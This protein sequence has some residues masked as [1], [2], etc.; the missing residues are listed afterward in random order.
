MNYGAPNPSGSAPCG[1]NGTQL[2][3]LFEVNHEVAP[4]GSTITNNDTALNDGFYGL[5]TV[6]Q[7]D[8]SLACSIFGACN[9]ESLPGSPDRF[10]GIDQEPP[11]VTVTTPDP[12]VA[13]TTVTLDITTGDALPSSSGNI[14]NLSGVAKVQCSNDDVNFTTCGSGTVGWTIPSGDGV[15]TVYVKVTD[16]TGNTSEDSVNINLDTTSPT[17]H[18]VSPSAAS[19]SGWLLG[20]PSSF[21]IAG[22][23]ADTDHLDWW[24]DGGGH[25]SCSSPCT[26]TGGVIPNDGA[27]SFH[28]QAVDKVGNMEAA[29]DQPFMIDADKPLVALLTVPTAVDGSNGWFQENPFFVINAVDIT[30][31]S[32][33]NGITYK[34]RPAGVG[35]YGPDTPYLGPFQLGPGEWDICIKSQ[36]LAGNPAIPSGDGVN[37]VTGCRL[38]V[39]IDDAAPT[40]SLKTQ[41]GGL[42]HAPDGLN[43]WFVSTPTVV[44]TPSDATPG[45]GL[46]ATYASV[47]HKPYQAYTGPITIPEGLHEVRAFTVDNSGQVSN[48]AILPVKVDLSPAEPAAR[49]IPIDPARNGWFRR[50]S[51]A[52]VL[53]AQDGDQNAGTHKIV[54]QIVA[55]TASVPAACNPLWTTYTGQ[56]TTV[57]PGPH[58]VD[59]CTEDEAGNFSSVRSKA[60]NIDPDN[61]IVKALDANPNIWISVLG[62]LGPP[63]TQLQWQVTE[64]TSGKVT[65]SVVVYNLL[66]VP[67]RQINEAAP[68]T[69]TPGVPLNGSTPWDGKDNTLTGIVP[70]GVYYYRVVVTDDAGNTAMSGESRPITIKVK[71]L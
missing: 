12:T 35:A 25:T 68:R 59:F 8:N 31:G 18:L 63:T 60:F 44:A 23:N 49:T 6:V 32:G 7:N 54:Y 37:P 16:A 40:V 24:F 13:K 29:H 47:D 21:T 39:K 3:H 11:T 34:T 20:P 4:D 5:Y 52:F 15:H 38:D 56:L 26:V 2:G 51:P 17:S 55:P 1:S 71:L 27:H 14:D 62:I 10:I 58:R 61:P 53:R 9:T 43:G 57:A 65:V 64:P 46:A 70:A 36:D 22:D 41:I 45:S 30:G 28:W 66:G 42:D 48:V 50:P 33:V 69:V 67:V 19:L